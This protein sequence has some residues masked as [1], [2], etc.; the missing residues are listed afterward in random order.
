MTRFR[1]DLTLL[2]EIV[3]RI[4]AFDGHVGQALE[5]VDRQVDC[6]HATWTGEAA[7]QHRVAHEEW[8]RG[9]AGMREGLSKM[10]DAARTAHGNY[11]CAV[12]VNTAMWEQ[13]R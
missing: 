13:T 9:V 10:R 3:G 1:V 7:G 8:R 12:A 5:D 2:S 4:T 6:L 11:T